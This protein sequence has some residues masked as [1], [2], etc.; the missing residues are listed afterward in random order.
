MG[1]AEPRWCVC[2]EKTQPRLCL[3][4]FTPQRGPLETVFTAGVKHPER[5]CWKERPHLTCLYKMPFKHFDPP[6]D[7]AAGDKEACVLA[8]HEGGRPGV[9]GG[10]KGPDEGHL[11]LLQH[12]KQALLG[13]ELG[14]V[15]KCVLVISEDVG[16]RV[17]ASSLHYGCFC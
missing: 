10:V 2:L 13:E 12:C 9:R 17:E 14:H 3:S 15:R 4:S 6:L 11:A 1:T 8:A 5:S 16:T 7:A